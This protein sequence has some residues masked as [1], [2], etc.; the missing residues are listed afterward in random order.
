MLLKKEKSH[1]KGNHLPK[2]VG[3]E[4]IEPEKVSIC[5]AGKSCRESWAIVEKQGVFLPGEMETETL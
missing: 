5:S 1:Q 3:K 2:K 4:I